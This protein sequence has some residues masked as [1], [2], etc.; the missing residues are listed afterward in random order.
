[1]VKGHSVEIVKESERLKL[2][3]ARESA[4]EKARVE[5]KVQRKQDK[6]AE[7]RAAEMRAL[8]EELEAK[9]IENG[10]DADFILGQEFAEPHGN[11]GS[12]PIVG[13]AGGLM[14]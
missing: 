10:T 5:A 9:Y 1:M 7:K 8:K 12:T 6:E 2:K 14:G 3:R 11:F 13:V 4:E